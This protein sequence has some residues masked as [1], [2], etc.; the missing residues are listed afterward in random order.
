MV[1]EIVGTRGT[2]FLF[3]GDQV[4]AAIEFDLLRR[5]DLAD[6]GRDYFGLLFVALALLKEAFVD[7]H[8]VLVFNEK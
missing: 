6:A 8:L 2:Y 1:G 7:F 5:D 3:G 4:F